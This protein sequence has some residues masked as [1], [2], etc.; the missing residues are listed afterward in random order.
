VAVRTWRTA[1]GVSEGPGRS[2][3]GAVVALR[4]A[5]GVQA[6]ETEAADVADLK[7]SQPDVEQGALVEGAVEEVLGRG[8][9]LGDRDVG[10]VAAVPSE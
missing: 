3:A 2:A 1:T 10:G 6:V 9:D 5:V 8:T 7:I 4:C